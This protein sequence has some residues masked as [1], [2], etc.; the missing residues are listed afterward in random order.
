MRAILKMHSS[1][2]QA[3]RD[4]LERP[5][6]FAFE[7]AGFIE[8]RAAEIQNGIMVLAQ[9]YHPIADNDYVPDEKVG[10]RINGSAIRS[11]MQTSLNSGAGIFHVHMHEHAGIPRPSRI[12]LVEG[13]KLIPDFFSV[14]PTAPHG[15]IIL[16]TDEAFG[17]CWLGRAKTLLPFSVIMISGAPIHLVDIRL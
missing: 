8:C 1:L 4:D 5:H 10:A 14:T 7:R 6:Q 2:A 13:G 12:D 9:S 11:A 16:S 3:I 15:M 17:L